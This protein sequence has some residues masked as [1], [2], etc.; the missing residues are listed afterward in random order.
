VTGSGDLSGPEDAERMLRETGCAAVMFARGAMGNPFIFT[1]TRS[2]LS[3]G[4]WTPASPAARAA[5]AFRQLEMMAADMGER[6]ACLEMR[7][8][9]CAAVS[10]GPGRPGIPGGAALRGRLAQA[11]TIAAYRQI[12]AEAGLLPENAHSQV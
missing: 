3:A 10:G 8:Q 6:G 2:F 1:E 12:L 7:K 11:E 9:F 5:A 4:S